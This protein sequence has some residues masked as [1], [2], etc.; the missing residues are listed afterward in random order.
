MR[1]AVGPGG[2]TL[3]DFQREVMVTRS[4]TPEGR[5]RDPVPV[6]LENRKLAH[7]P[8]AGG[9]FFRRGILHDS[10]SARL[11][12][13]FCLALQRDKIPDLGHGYAVP[14][15]S[16]AVLRFE[17]H[18]PLPSKCVL[19]LAHKHG[20][21][22]FWVARRQYIPGFLRTVTVAGSSGICSHR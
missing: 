9:S 3:D 16:I 4:S 11:H 15:H 1:F 7:A 14:E 12:G 5:Q 18:R 21:L 20:R 19:K 22:H 17:L 13:S 8:C 6:L 10:Q 2:E